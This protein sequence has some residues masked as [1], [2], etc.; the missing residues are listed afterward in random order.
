MT[1]LP[2]SKHHYPLEAHF[3]IVHVIQTYKY[4]IKQRINMSFSHFISPTDLSPNSACHQTPRITQILSLPIVLKLR[5]P[6]DSAYF[7]SPQIFVI[8]PSFMDRNTSNLKC[9]VRANTCWKLPISRKSQN[10]Y[11]SMGRN[12][13]SRFQGFTANVDRFLRKLTRVTRQ[14]Q[15]NDY[16]DD[17]RYEQIKKHTDKIGDAGLMDLC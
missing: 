7:G 5:P 3:P 6:K 12:S 17:T 2:Y 16:N 14:Q 11:T 10:V 9:I 13:L 8:K 1:T 15:N 4:N